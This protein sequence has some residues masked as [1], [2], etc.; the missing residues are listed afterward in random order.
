MYMYI[1]TLVV[2]YRVARKRDDSGD[3]NLREV[4]VLLERPDIY[5]IIIILR[6]RNIPKRAQVVRPGEFNCVVALLLSLNRS[7]PLSLA[8]QQR[9]R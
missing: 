7:P 8:T 6:L 2:I 1:R 3:G 5:Y 4:K 9:F